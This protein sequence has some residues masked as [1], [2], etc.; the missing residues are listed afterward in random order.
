M[1]GPRIALA[2]GLALTAIAVGVILSRS[3]ITVA[4]TNS[5]K[6]QQAVAYMHTSET[7]CQEGGTLPR[8]TSAIRVSMLANI[9]P[10]VSLRVL[11]GSRVVTQGEHPAG[12]GEDETVTVPVRPIPHAVRDVVV[13]TTVG[14][15]IEFLQLNGIRATS[16]SREASGLAG[17]KLRM[18]YLRP[19]SESWLSL[20]VS[21]S[22]R[23]GLGHAAPGTWIVF[24]LLTLVIA[25]A[26]LASRLTLEELR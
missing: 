3:P 24:L 25:V 21:I 11:E 18:E 7:G 12:W 22:R 23:L 6:A 19:G 16:A 2:V 14:P 17:V 20:S 1:S 4:G 15:A 26:V 9:G 5:V 10:K 13:C 8:E